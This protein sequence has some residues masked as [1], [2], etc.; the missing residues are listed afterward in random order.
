[1]YMEY[2]DNRSILFDNKDIVP[3]CSLCLDRFHFLHCFHCLHC[4]GNHSWSPPAWA[5]L[6]FFVTF[7]VSPVYDSPPHP[8]SVTAGITIKSRAIADS[9]W[10]QSCATVWTKL[11]V[12][13]LHSAQTIWYSSNWIA[14]HRFIKTFFWNFQKCMA[15]L[16]YILIHKQMLGKILCGT[17]HLN[18][19]VPGAL[20]KVTGTVGKRGIPEKGSQNAV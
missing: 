13:N 8:N 2:F 19:Q 12:S 14:L 6:G 3:C 20:C 17:W 15:D 9:I 5:H 16:C 1:M 4:L 11:I 10:R 18:F 7:L